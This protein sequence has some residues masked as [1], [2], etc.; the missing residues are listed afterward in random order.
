MSGT[1][2]PQGIAERVCAALLAVAEVT[3][4]LLFADQ[5]DDPDRE[6]DEELQ[7]GD[8]LGFDSV[9]LMELKYRLETRFPELGE[10]SLPEMLPYLDTVG[11][12]FGYLTRRLSLVGAS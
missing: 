12:L 3:P 6:L 4:E 5:A 2:G 10:L 11:S 7:F 9:M 1:A 8:D